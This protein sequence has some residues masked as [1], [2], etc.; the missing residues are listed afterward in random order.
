MFNKLISYFNKYQLFYKHHYGFRPNHSTIHPI[1]HLL[2]NI[3]NAND[4]IN[5]KTHY[6]YFVTY[7][8]AFD[9]LDRKILLTKLQYYGIRGKV[10]DWLS[11]YLFERTQFVDF[12][13]TFSKPVQ[14]V[15]ACPRVPH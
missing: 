12:Y 13:G 5:K 2:N 1:I 3:P 15:M 11:N 10:L 7:T 6:P 4:N 8:K 14:Y 9:V